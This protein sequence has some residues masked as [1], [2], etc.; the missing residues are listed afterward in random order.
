MNRQALPLLLR[1]TFAALLPLVLGLACAK[2]PASEVPTAPP[3]S[4][5]PAPAPEKLSLALNWVAEPEF[6]GIYAA[7]ETG[8]FSRNG[9]DV[10]ISGGGDAVLK[11]LAAGKT[12]LGI[13][14][15]DEIVIAR[16]QGID[17]V[18]L[19]A[20][21]QT[22][23]QGLMTR[24]DRGIATIGELFGKPGTIAMQPG[25]AYKDFLGK[26]FGFSKV[27][28]VPYDG[29]VARFLAEKN[30]AQQCFVTAEPLAA[31]KAGVEPK[32]F[33]IADA[34]YNPYTAV[35]AASGDFVRS[36]GGTAGRVVTALREGWRS[37]LDDPAKT[38]LAMEKLNTA[39]APETFAEGATAQE[40]LIETEETKVRGLGSMTAARWDELALQL[41]EL[42]VVKEAVD[43]KSCFVELPAR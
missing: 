7:R 29:G 31:R 4:T 36:R 15:A 8:A 26:K 34:G 40:P 17:V 35:V 25:L 14:S 24:A 3:A 9:L 21:Y 18:G 32:V 1:R 22:S 11:M 42:G 37:Y 38:N 13:L 27:K 41:R 23:P 12:D 2:K 20:T 19:F 5:V 39:M 16:A 43:G 6:G 30:Y 28:V 33:L 10:E